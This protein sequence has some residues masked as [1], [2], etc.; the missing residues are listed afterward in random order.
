[1]FHVK[2]IPLRRPNVSRGTVFSKRKVGCDQHSFHMEQVLLGWPS[3]P[4][5]VPH[6]TNRH[7]RPDSRL[8]L[9][10]HVKHFR[11]NHVVRQ[12]LYVPR[13]T[14]LCVFCPISTAEHSVPRETSCILVAALLNFRSRE[15]VG[16]NHRDCKPKGWSWQDNHGGESGRLSRHG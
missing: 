5:S 10:F 3:K 9:M 1:M 6:G 14:T 4:E 16:S 8:Q 2:H 12:D 11:A 15:T 7:P 13:G